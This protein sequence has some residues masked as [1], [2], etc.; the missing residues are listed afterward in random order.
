MSSARKKYLL[1][2]MALFFAMAVYQP[3]GGNLEMW[4]FTY[5]GMYK[6]K[7]RTQEFTKILVEYT[8]PGKPPRNVVE[9]RN[10]YYVCEKIRDILTDSITNYNNSTPVYNTRVT[11]D[12]EKLE[13]VRRIVVLDALP[14]LEQ[15]QWR[16]PE[17]I[18]T[19]R[20][21]QWDQFELKNRNTPDRDQ[22]VVS[23]RLGDVL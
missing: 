15:K 2:L 19:V 22:T 9:G 14:I 7:V 4:P 8:E 6:G 18:V 23:V 20:A 10:G 17:A 16:N 11:L 1:I 5:F 12:A 3:L 13:R 21:L